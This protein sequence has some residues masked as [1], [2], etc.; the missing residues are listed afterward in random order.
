MNRILYFIASLVLHLAIWLI[1]LGILYLSQLEA[2]ALAASA[3]LLLTAALGI[4]WARYLDG[5]YLGSF[6]AGSAVSTVLLLG[7]LTVFD[8]SLGLP[9][10]EPLTLD[11]FREFL[12]GLEPSAAM[13]LSYAGPILIIF[14]ISFGGYWVG[15]RRSER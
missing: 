1:P 8:W 14:G 13:L 3:G 10:Q 15:S 12:L 2:I 11:G 6:L 5:R 4:T 9:R 7:L